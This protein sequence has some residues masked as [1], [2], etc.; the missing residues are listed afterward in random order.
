[1]S[2]S[3]DMVHLFNHHQLT[4]C[5]LVKLVDALDYALL[6]GAG[7]QTAEVVQ[8]EHTGTHTITRSRQRINIEYRTQEG[9]Q[10]RLQGCG[11]EVAPHLVLP[12]LSVPSQ[13]NV[14]KI[15]SAPPSIN[16]HLKSNDLHHL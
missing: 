2:G 11:T 4:N 7:G 12:H 8:A 1:M 15:V 9:L 14:K 16:V 6:E 3:I 5:E 13:H 10:R